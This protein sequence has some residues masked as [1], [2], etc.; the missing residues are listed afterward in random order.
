MCTVHFV[1]ALVRWCLLDWEEFRVIVNLPTW[2]VTA[3]LPLKICKHANRNAFCL[4]LLQKKKTVAIL[5]MA[6]YSLC[7]MGTRFLLNLT[8]KL[9]NN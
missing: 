7:L 5:Q 1:S 9:T 4:V 3:V 8:V 6:P 2:I